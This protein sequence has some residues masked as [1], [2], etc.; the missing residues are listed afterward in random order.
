MPVKYTVKQQITNNVWK[1]E[2]GKEKVFRIDKAIYVGRAPRPGSTISKAAELVDVTD[3]EDG[4][5]KTL[6]VGQVI[7]DNLIERYPDDGYV[8]KTFRAVQGPVPTGKKYKT[9]DIAEV[10]VGESPEE[11]QP[12]KPAR[13]R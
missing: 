11:T 7:K 9:Y 4:Q 1:W 12:T 5:K 3:V 8:G 6:I 13:R 2:E 10:E